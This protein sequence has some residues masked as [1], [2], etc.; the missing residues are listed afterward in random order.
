MNRDADLVKYYGRRNNKNKDRVSVMDLIFEDQPY[1]REYARQ[2][3]LVGTSL[4]KRRIVK[5]FK[6]I[7]NINLKSLYR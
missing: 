4:K 3:S 6:K 2:R 1:L 5:S 7:E